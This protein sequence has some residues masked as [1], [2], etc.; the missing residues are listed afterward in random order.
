M[1]LGGDDLSGILTVSINGVRGILAEGWGV[2]VGA[3]DT[4]IWAFEVLFCGSIHVL[5]VILCEVWGIL[6]H[7]IVVCHMLIGVAWGIM[8]II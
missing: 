6:D 4:V 8:G 2:H 5:I 7:G 1:I 3:Y